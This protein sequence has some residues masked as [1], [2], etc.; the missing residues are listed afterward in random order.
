MGTLGNILT[1]LKQELYKKFGYN[2]ICLQHAV[3]SDTVLYICIEHD[4]RSVMFG[5]VELTDN[6]WVLIGYDL[7]IF[8]F[9]L[10]E[11][12]KRKQGINTLV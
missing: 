5:Q 9:E 6:G 11:Y 7:E 4:S 1:N 12:N 3:N 8:K 10:D 2:R